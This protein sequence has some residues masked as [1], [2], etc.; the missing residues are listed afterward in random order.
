MVYGLISRLALLYFPHIPK[1]GGETLK[2]VFYKRFGKDKCLKI[3]GADFGADYSAREF[4]ELPPDVLNNYEVVLGHL[5]VRQ[6]FSNSFAQDCQITIITSVREP[7]SRI[8]SLYNFVCCNPRHPDHEKMLDVEPRTFLRN[9]PA[10]VQFHFLARDDKQGIDE[11]FETTVIAPMERSIRVFC[12]YLDQENRLAEE[13]FRIKN[14][15]VDRASDGQRLFEIQDLDDRDIEYLRARH[16][17]DHE[18]YQRA[19]LGTEKFL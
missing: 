1:A 9:Q 12:S 8:V 2:K 4:E 10:N 11:I 13:S 19:L 7:I 17:I 6:F 15:T 18:I 16:S 14:R 5:P 3:W